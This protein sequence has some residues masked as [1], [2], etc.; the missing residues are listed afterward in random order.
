MGW[1]AASTVQ[2]GTGILP[3]HGH[4]GR[5]RTARGRVHRR[6]RPASSTA[7]PSRSPRSCATRVLRGRR[8]AAVRAQRARPAARPLAAQRGRGDRARRLRPVLRRDHPRAAAG[9]H[10]ARPA[11][12]HL[13]QLPGAGPR[14]RVRRAAARGHQVAAIVLAGSG[15]HDAAFTAGARRRSCAAYEATGGRVAVIGRHEHARRRGACRTTRPAAS[16]SATQLFDAGPPRDRRD[17]RPA[18]ADHD[19]R[20]ARRR[21]PG[22]QGARPHAA[23]PSGSSTPTS[24]GTAAPRR[25]SSC[26]TPTRR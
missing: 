11:G 19:H 10:R 21:A 23:R 5:C 9:R 14:A 4:L 6:P 8:R 12:D 7:A 3:G 1:C 26:S 13:Q 15:Y 25:P 24:P 2:A 22:R 16:C 18:R 17:R 20:P